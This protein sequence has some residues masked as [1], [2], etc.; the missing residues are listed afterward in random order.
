[1]L[2]E[3]IERLKKEHNITMYEWS[4]RAGIPQ[5]LL[6]LLKNGHS[7][8]LNFETVVKLADALNI[9]LDEFRKG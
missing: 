7:K 5:S 3:N 2:R 9:S 8:G 6:I 4:K 1:M